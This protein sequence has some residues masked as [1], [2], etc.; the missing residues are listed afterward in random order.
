MGQRVSFL[1]GFL[2]VTSSGPDTENISYRS[3]Q[4][5]FRESVTARGETSLAEPPASPG[6]TPGSQTTPRATPVGFGEPQ[7]FG[8]FP[9]PQKQ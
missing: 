5:L 6:P 7:A 3:T 8:S 9:F 4:E 2:D 1:T